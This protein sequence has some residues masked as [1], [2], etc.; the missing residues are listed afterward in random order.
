M[1]NIKSINGD[2]EDFGNQELYGHIKYECT[3]LGN[4]L[5]KLNGNLNDPFH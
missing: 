5:E 4:T 1:E 3:E 2:S